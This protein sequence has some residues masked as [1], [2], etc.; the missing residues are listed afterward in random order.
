MRRIVPSDADDQTGGKGVITTSARYF[1]LVN[2]PY[3][4]TMETDEAGRAAAER[5]CTRAHGSAEVPAP[6]RRGRRAGKAKSTP[7]PRTVKQ[8]SPATR[9][10]G[11]RLRMF[12]HASC[13]RRISPPGSA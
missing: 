1:E 3:L 6:E 9:R 12:P 8:P 5:T 4:M 13:A 2:L 10:T 7:S 11:S